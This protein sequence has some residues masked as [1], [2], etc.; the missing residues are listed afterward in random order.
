MIEDAAQAIIDGIERDK[1]Q[2]YVGNDAKLMNVFYRIS[3]L[4]ATKFMYNQM[5]G[6]LSQ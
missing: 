4:R 5:K 3:P 1:F 2:V 6:L